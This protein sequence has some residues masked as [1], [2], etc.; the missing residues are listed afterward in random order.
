MKCRLKNI[1]GLVL[2]VDGTLTL[3]RRSFLLD[4]E[5]I[6]MLQQIA[7]KIPVVL[8]SG[9]AIPVVAALS[10]YLGFDSW[11]H[12]GEN[13]CIVYYREQIQHICRKS[14]RDAAIIV[15]REMSNILRPSW[16]NSFRYYDFAYVIMGRTNIEI[17]RKDVR[18]ILNS[19]GFDWVK[20]SFSGYALHFRPP[21]ASKGV[22]AL[23]ALKIVDIDPSCVVAIGDGENDVEFVEAGFRTYAVANADKKLKRVAHEIIPAPS[24]QGVKLFIQKLYRQHLLNQ[25]L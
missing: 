18:K 2:D 10:R 20:L 12:V 25:E 3:D 5:L 4:L 7:A 13:G 21:E 11:P 8:V 9:N 1:C 24:S 6:R 15:E 19:K 23:K 22:G 17:V 14:T 16:Q